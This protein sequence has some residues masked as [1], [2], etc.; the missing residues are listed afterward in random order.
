MILGIILQRSEQI[1]NEDICMTGLG[2]ETGL[3]LNS[4]PYLNGIAQEDLYK[5][6]FE[7]SL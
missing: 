7:S 6:S 2:I 5:T 1:Y 4:F 3:D